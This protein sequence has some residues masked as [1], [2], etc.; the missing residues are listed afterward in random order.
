MCENSDLR[1][2][3]IQL[4][5]KVKEAPQKKSTSPRTERMSQVL[6]ILLLSFKFQGWRSS[7]CHSTC[8]IISPWKQIP[9]L[10]RLR[11]TRVRN[12]NIADR[13]HLSTSL[14]FY[15]FAWGRSINPSIKRLEI[16]CS[17]ASICIVTRWGVGLFFS[18]SLFLRQ[19]LGA[20]FCD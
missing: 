1:M 11:L 3:A 18:C 12:C 19:R 7:V 4:P 20:V 10:L 9:R 16:C 8:C 6:K 17:L 2:S 14:I 15:C 13:W 5:R